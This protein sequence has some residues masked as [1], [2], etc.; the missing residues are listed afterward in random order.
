MAHF[1]CFFFCGCLVVLFPPQPPSPWTTLGSGALQVDQ[2][3]DQVWPSSE[4]IFFTEKTTG[5]KHP[6][7]VLFLGGKGEKHGKLWEL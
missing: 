7:L 3:T 2:I 1:F 6:R 5:K 4:E